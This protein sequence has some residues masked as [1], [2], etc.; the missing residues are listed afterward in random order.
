M[1]EGLNCLTN[2]KAQSLAI[3]GKSRLNIEFNIGKKGLW[4]DL[5]MNHM[6]IY[7]NLVAQNNI[8]WTEIFQALHVGL[9][10]RNEY[11]Q[12]GVQ[13]FQSS[14]TPTILS[15]LKYVTL[16]KKIT[17]ELECHDNSSTLSYIIVNL[18]QYGK[19]FHI[20]GKEQEKQKQKQKKEIHFIYYIIA[21]Y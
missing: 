13:F 6:K 18:H 10:Q 1:K 11:F 19:D 7:V 20:S 4:K 5:R 15:K 8:A 14:W 16:Q 12:C 9:G 2:E 3:N 17:K 21:F